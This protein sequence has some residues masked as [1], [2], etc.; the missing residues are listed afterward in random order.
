[1]SAILKRQ[2][3]VDIMI[4]KMASSGLFYTL[5]NLSKAASSGT[6]LFGQILLKIVQTVLFFALNYDGHIQNT[7]SFYHSIGGIARKPG[8]ISEVLSDSSFDSTMPTWPDDNAPDLLRFLSSPGQ[9]DS[10][11]IDLNAS[12]LTNTTG[13]RFNFEFGKKINFIKNFK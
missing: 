1:M 2:G 11:K 10:L 9:S 6:D 3:F 4:E 13:E 8:K 5:H 7:E 12:V